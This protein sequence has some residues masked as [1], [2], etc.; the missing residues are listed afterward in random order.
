MARGMDVHTAIKE[1]A[2]SMT[3]DPSQRMNNHS[4]VQGGNSSIIDLQRATTARRMLLKRSATADAAAAEG[5]RRQAVQKAREASKHNEKIP[6]IAALHGRRHIW[7]EVDEPSD[8]LQKE[9]N[10]YSQKR[11]IALRIALARAQ[12]REILKLKLKRKNRKIAQA[13]ASAVAQAL[14]K[15]LENGNK[16]AGIQRYGQDDNKRV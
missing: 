3:N 7:N 10:M 1:L 11:K 6:S 14:R 12:H 16:H 15:Q 5:R 2:A 8:A 4:E 13:A 9:K